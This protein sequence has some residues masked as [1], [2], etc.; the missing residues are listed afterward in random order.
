ME[1][2]IAIMQ[3]YFF[4]YIGYW[5]LINAVDVF[6]IY[7]DGYFIKNGWMHKNRIMNYSSDGA[8]DIYLQIR[9]KSGLGKNTRDIQLLFDINFRKKTLREI[10]T[11]YHRAPYFKE[12]MDVITPVFLNSN[13]NMVEYLYDEILRVC[14]YLNIKTKLILSSTINKSDLD[15]VEQKAFRICHTVGIYEYINPIGGVEFYNKEFW[16]KNGVSISFLKRDEIEYQQFNNRFIP[17][18]SIIDIMMFNSPEE[19]G[20]LLTKYHLL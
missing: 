3:P 17:D 4:P 13:E 18:L 16:L 12:I 10:E 6:V 9:N 5:Q 8:R 14:K 1:E 15:C 2:R 7:D 20:E 19:I 11:R